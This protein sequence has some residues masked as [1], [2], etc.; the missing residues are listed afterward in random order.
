MGR[1]VMVKIRERFWR[2]RI[3]LCAAQP[4]ISENCEVWFFDLPSSP[5]VP[6]SQCICQMCTMC[7]TFNKKFASI[8]VLLRDLWH[9]EKLQLSPITNLVPDIMTFV[10]HRGQ[11]ISFTARYSLNIHST[12][13]PPFLNV[14]PA[15]ASWAGTAVSTNSLPVYKRIKTNN[16]FYQLVLPLNYFNLTWAWRLYGVRIIRFS[17]RLLTDSV[18]FI[19]KCVDLSSAKT[20]MCSNFTD[21]YK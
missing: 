19:L 3:S 14:M 12:P 7:D 11:Q 5:E 8:V 9:F 4:G 21:D 15:V 2:P 20:R 6:Q 13:A 10:R 18:R 16:A 17:Q 1:G